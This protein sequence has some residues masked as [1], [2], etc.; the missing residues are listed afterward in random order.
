MVVIELVGIL[1][2]ST[3]HQAYVDDHEKNRGR[4][5]K[6]REKEEA[7]CISVC[8]V[9]VCVCACEAGV[10]CVCVRGVDKAHACILPVRA[11]CAEC[12]FR[13][14]AFMLLHS[15]PRERLQ[16]VGDLLPD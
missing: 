15:G 11:V 5:K 12:G 1:F 8:G 4:G 9:C 16:I 14:Y 7:T 13:A 10:A 3:W 2:D 6:Q